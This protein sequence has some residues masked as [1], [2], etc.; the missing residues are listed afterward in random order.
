MPIPFL[1]GLNNPVDRFQTLQPVVFIPIPSSPFD[2]QFGDFADVGRPFELAERGVAAPDAV[3]AGA[4]N[5]AFPAL[6][7][8]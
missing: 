3:R 2:Q 4:F 8:E 6:F 1:P 5:L 7:V